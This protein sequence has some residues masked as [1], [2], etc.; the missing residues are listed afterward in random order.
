MED[1]EV[2]AAAQAED[3]NADEVEEPGQIRPLLCPTH[4]GTQYGMPYCMGS[5]GSGDRGFA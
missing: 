5:M 2:A 1:K 4:Y 3:E